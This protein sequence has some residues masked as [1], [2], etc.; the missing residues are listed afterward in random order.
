LDQ[1]SKEK[2]KKKIELTIII[3]II[4]LNVFDF[5]G[6]L[7]TDISFMKLMISWIVLG[8]IIY[9]IGLTKIFFDNESK[10]IDFILIM[11]YFML[12]SKNFTSFIVNNISTADVLLPLFELIMNNKTLIENYSFI[13][14]ILVITITSLY[15][16][17]KVEIRKPSTAAIFEE[18]GII[19][20][21][22]IIKRIIRF[23]K[24]YLII[25]AFFIIV[26]N[27]LMEWLAIMVDAPLAMIGI[28]FYLVIFIKHKEFNAENFI[29]KV[30]SFGNK[31]YEN[32]INLFKQ[33]EG[34]LIGISGILI[35]HLLVDLGIFILPYIFSF[36]SNAY[37]TNIT[38]IELLHL[39]LWT[40][41]LNNIKEVN[42]IQI[43]AIIYTYLMNLISIILMLSLPSYLWYKIVKNEYIIFK[44]WLYGLF[45][46]SVFLFLFKPI[47]KILPLNQID[48]A[49]VDI[50]TK[51]LDITNIILF[52]I[53]SLIIFLLFFIITKK[54]S[55][56]I[57]FTLL[58]MSI[59]SFFSYYIYCYSSSIIKNYINIIIILFNNNNLLYIYL[60][61][62]LLITG[63]YY[64][65]AYI[66][67]M[68]AIIYYNYN[69]L[70]KV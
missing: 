43:I 35:L 12:I 52:S 27:L 32:F 61:L 37:L 67:L 58:S 4:L 48:F 30:G 1:K 29:Y 17:F 53:I 21:F 50:I 2:I 39:S 3:A 26:F 51:Q 66:S 22:N 41:L 6:M 11:S 42:P 23:I 10:N 31:F 25:F 54:I 49:G 13:L 46:S 59:L 5:F 16:S 14:G 18:E 36:K 64:L 68:I 20:G 9:H 34:I 47:F 56:K 63:I 57:T 15:L 8:Y 40:H 60:S 65:I 33:K 7:S 55:E 69:Y 45:F 19:N 62:F 44:P 70:K 24:I 38:N 28:I